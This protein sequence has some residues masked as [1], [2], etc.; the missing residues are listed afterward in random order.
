MGV[1]VPGNPNY[2]PSLAL[3]GQQV[4]NTNPILPINENDGTPSI[5]QSDDRGLPMNQIEMMDSH[6][7]IGDDQQDPILSNLHPEQADPINFRVAEHPYDHLAELRDNYVSISDDDERVG[8]YRTILVLLVAYL[9]RANS[10]F[11][12]HDVGL[13]LN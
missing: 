9:C 1:S 13:S 7:N 6:T 12:L 3:P 11:Q 10:A 5:R 2:L 4:A 8:Y